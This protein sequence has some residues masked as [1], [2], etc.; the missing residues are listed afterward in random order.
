M[1]DPAA[2]P[3]LFTRAEDGHTGA[4]TVRQKPDKVRQKPDTTA[5]RHD[6]GMSIRNMTPGL[7]VQPDPPPG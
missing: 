4:G 6:M 1:Q 2:W 5:R 3:A 7:I